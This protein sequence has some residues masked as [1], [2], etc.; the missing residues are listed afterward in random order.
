MLEK[1]VNARQRYNDPRSLP[2]ETNNEMSGLWVC[3]PNSVLSDALVTVSSLR[4]TTTLQDKKRSLLYF[5]SF[6]VVSSRV[7]LRGAS[8]DD[9]EQGTRKPGNGWIRDSEHWRCWEHGL[10][11]TTKVL[12]NLR[13]DPITTA[14]RIINLWQ[15][16]G[17]RQTGKNS[18]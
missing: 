9:K 12:V 11:D 17:Q 2:G 15:C 18:Y 13:K 1:Y 16:I 7:T 6:K 5:H 8:S 3:P 4:S 14:I 10:P